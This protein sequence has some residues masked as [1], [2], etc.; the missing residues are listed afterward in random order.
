MV[1]DGGLL[2]ERPEARNNGLKPISSST[3]GFMHRNIARGLKH[4]V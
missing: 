1:G 3:Q 2:H 4:I